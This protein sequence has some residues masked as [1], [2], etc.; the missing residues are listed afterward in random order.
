VREMLMWDNPA[1]Y[2]KLPKGR[3]PFAVVWTKRRVREWQRAGERPV[4]AVWTP[5]MT[6]RQCS[7][8]STTPRPATR[9]PTDARPCATRSRLTHAW[10]G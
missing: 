7:C 5:A 1:R 4:V 3:R 2:L 9:A 6:T 8:S 10:L